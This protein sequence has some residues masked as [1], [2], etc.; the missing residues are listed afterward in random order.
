[1][2]DSK[3]CSEKKTVSQYH[4]FVH[5]AASVIMSNSLLVVFVATP[6]FIAI[7]M[8]WLLLLVVFL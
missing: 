8:S 6:M 1:M 7:V 2:A 5:A 4:W 3:E